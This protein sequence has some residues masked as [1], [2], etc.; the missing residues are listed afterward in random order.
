MRFCGGVHLVR[1]EVRLA[2]PPLHINI[3][4]LHIY[5]FPHTTIHYKSPFL[6]YTDTGFS[7]C[8]LLW[9]F[10][11]FHRGLINRSKTGVFTTSLYGDNQAILTRGHLQQW[12]GAQVV[13]DSGVFTPVVSAFFSST[14]SLRNYYG[15]LVNLLACVFLSML[16]LGLPKS[17]YLQSA[18]WMRCLEMILLEKSRLH[19]RLLG[20][21]SLFGTF[22]GSWA[23][24]R[25]FL[26]QFCHS[27]ISY[28]KTLFPPKSWK[29]RCETVSRKSFAAGRN[30]NS[31]ELEKVDEAESSGE[32][33]RWRRLWRH[34]CCARACFAAPQSGASPRTGKSARCRPFLWQKNSFQFFLKK[35]MFFLW[36]P[37][38]VPESAAIKSTFAFFI[39][40]WSEH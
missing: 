28:L 26:A 2:R 34:L 9:S 11:K 5:H 1:P 7:S 21:E 31:G 23:D 8:F 25:Y 17:V 4:C 14:I 32:Q 15:W 22:A 38:L 24:R 39:F 6:F 37:S 10:T 18:L 30:Q 19:G 29:S 3:P 12:P 33:Q 27:Y 20:V 13:G 36:E 16:R 40:H 35:E